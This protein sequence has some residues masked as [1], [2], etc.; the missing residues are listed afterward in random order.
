MCSQKHLTLLSYAAEKFLKTP[1]NQA[2]DILYKENLRSLE[3]RYEGSYPI[4][5]FS[6]DTEN[7]SYYLSIIEDE[8]GKLHKQID[9]YE[10]QACE[11]DDWKETEA[12]RLC[13]DIKYHITC[14]LPGYE[15]APW[16]I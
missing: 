11:S 1:R 2:F 12:F 13:D 9:C 4:D 8:M 15:E 14:R 3:S 7:T 6:I 5:S 10:Y 16:G